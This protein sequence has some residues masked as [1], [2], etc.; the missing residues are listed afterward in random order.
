MKQLLNI[1][2]LVL[3]TLSFGNCTKVVVRAKE[4]KTQPVARQYSTDLST[5]Y[6]QSKVALQRMGYDFI[7]E[8]ALGLSVQTRW[9]SMTSDSHYMMLFGRPDYAANQGGYYKLV[10]DVKQA[11]NSAVEVTVY[12][13][14]QTVAGELTSSEILE[15]KFHAK[16]ADA[17]RSPQIEVNNV[18]MQER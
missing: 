3:V 12:T 1:A 8:D 13:I 9:K 15:K 5:A 6:N 10:M 7:N 11:G 14:I 4:Q 16:L 2:V 18:G 17:L